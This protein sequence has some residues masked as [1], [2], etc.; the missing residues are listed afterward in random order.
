[1]THSLSHLE[2]NY[3]D[4]IRR[5]I[6]VSKRLATRSSRAS[7]I[8]VNDCSIEKEVQFFF[9]ISLGNIWWYLIVRR[10][11]HSPGVWNQPHRG[12]RVGPKLRGY[13]FHVPIIFQVKFSHITPK[14]LE[15]RDTERVIFCKVGMIWLQLW[16]FFGTKAKWLATPNK[17]HIPTQGIYLN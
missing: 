5:N 16:I 2:K 17:Q 1:M 7:S 13:N 3:N 9:I 4:T 11:T 12:W 14:M 15:A 6:K 10:Q 8:K